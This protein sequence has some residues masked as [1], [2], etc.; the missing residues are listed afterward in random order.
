MAHKILVVDDEKLIVK[1]IKF[2]LEQEQMEVE[3][4]FDG[5]DALN[6]ARR[7][8]YDLILL[9][10]MLPK[11]DG[12]DV[13]R[14]IREFSDVPI[15]ML[16]AKGEDMDKIMGLEHGADDYMTKPFNIVELKAR[17]KAILR[18]SR[19]DAP[20]DEKRNLIKIRGLEM[21]TGARRVF[22]K[23]RETEL[24]VKEFDLLQFFMENSGKVYSREHLLHT[25]WGSDF[26]GDVRTVDVHVRRIREKIEENPSAPKYIH[27]KWGV[28]YYF[29]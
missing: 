4:A 25:V 23:N 15:I 20:Q 22:L 24:T 9:D 5:E 8:N 27:T 28:G 10:V 17:I 12:L 7:N 11:L 14:Q 3:T 6:L 21:D 13:C 26:S 19:N 1:G 29:N 18:R 16:T 2:S